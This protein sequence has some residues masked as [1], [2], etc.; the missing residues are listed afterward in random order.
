MQAHLALAGLS[1]ARDLIRPGGWLKLYGSAAGFS[2]SALERELMTRHGVNFSVLKATEVADLEPRLNKN[3]YTRG[4]FQPGSGF[5][6]YP[7]ALAQSIWNARGNAAG[8]HSGDCPG[9]A[10]RDGGGVSIRTDKATRLFD[11]RWS[12]RPAH[13][14]SNLPRRWATRSAWT[15]SAATTSRLAVDMNLLGRPVCYPEKQCVLV[16][17]A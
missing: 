3:A 4:L 6:N 13:G 16:A 11:S 17:H 5:V 15:R 2:A 8:A 10:A 1:G 14:Q 7:M 12:S 9:T